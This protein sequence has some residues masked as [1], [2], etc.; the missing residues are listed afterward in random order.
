[1]VGLDPCGTAGT[2]GVRR[3]QVLPR[4]TGQRARHCPGQGGSPSSACALSNPFEPLDLNNAQCQNV[5]TTKDVGKSSSPPAEFR[6]PQS[7]LPP[8][9]C[10]LSRVPPVIVAQSY[11]VGVEARNVPPGTICRGLVYFIKFPLKIFSLPIGI[12]PIS[13][14]PVPGQTWSWV[15]LG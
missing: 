15:D 9:V 10:S 1:M 3:G 5:R 4:R 8:F 13:A 6:Y 12:F 2:C 7:P 11:K 14:K